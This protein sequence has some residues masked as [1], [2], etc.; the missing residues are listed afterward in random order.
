MS[1]KIYYPAIF[2]KE[3]TGYSVWVPDISGCVTQGENIQEASE[4]IVDAIGC[5][6][7][8]LSEHEMDIPAPS[9]PEK[10]KVG[11][12]QFVSIVPFDPI[13]FDKK[14]NSKA[15]KKTLTIPNWLNVM[16][17]KYNVNF[18]AVLQEGLMQKLHLSE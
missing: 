18:S 17:E 13:E 1:T 14:Y 12:N 15:V 5:M 16:A 7:E 3:E 8:I 10:I 11:E 2:Q 9:A 6:L 4:N